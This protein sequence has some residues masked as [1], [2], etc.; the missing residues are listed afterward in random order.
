MT[1]HAASCKVHIRLFIKLLAGKLGGNVFD[2]SVGRMMN[3]A[4]KLIGGYG[5]ALEVDLCHLSQFYYLMTN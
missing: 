1:I 2:W 5:K 3:Y 4:H